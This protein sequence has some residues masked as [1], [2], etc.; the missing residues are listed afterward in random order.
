[1]VNVVVIWYIFY[2]LGMLCQEKSSNPVLQSALGGVI[3]K[4]KGIILC[5]LRQSIF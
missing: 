1:M 4:L 3:H 2:R 5:E